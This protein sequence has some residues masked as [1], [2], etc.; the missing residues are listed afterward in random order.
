[1]DLRWTAGVS[2]C[3]NQGFDISNLYARIREPRPRKMPLHIRQIAVPCPHFSAGK[4]KPKHPD[5]GFGYNRESAVR[6]RT[7]LFFVFLRDSVPPCCKGFVFGCAFVAQFYTHK[8]RSS[9]ILNNPNTTIR[10]GSGQMGQEKEGPP[11]HWHSSGSYCFWH[12]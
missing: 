6:N 2:F 8:H 9:Q 3:Q 12:C 7:H 1:M 10:A 5:T 11:W 4:R